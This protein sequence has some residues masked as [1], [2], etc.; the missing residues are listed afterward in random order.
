MPR[1]VTCSTFDLSKAES[2]SGSVLYHGP[3]KDGIRL[4]PPR[5]LHRFKV[6]ESAHVCVVAHVPVS[7]EYDRTF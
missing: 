5:Q 2:M 6:L 1:I 3:Q 7:G 4:A